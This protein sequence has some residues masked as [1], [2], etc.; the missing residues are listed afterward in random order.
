MEVT[1]F[2]AIYWFGI[3]KTIAAAFKSRAVA[4]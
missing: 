3:F 1:V 4:P 2:L